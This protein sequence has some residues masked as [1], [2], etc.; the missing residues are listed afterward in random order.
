MQRIKRLERETEEKLKEAD[1]KIKTSF[2]L[3]RQDVD[4]MEKTIAAM[5]SYLKKKDLQFFD[6]R[7]KDKRIRDEFQ[8]DVDEFTQKIKQLNLAFDKVRQ[9]Q[10]EV[11]LRKDLAA[12]ED[13]IKTSFKNEIDSYKEQIKTLKSENKDQEKR[14]SAIENGYVREKKKVWFFKKKEE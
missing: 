10:R 7:K 5:R 11:V 6:D 4:E 14:I 13:R 3:I 8:K 1:R 9:I 12:I 2:A